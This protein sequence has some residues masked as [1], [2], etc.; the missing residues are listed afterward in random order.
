MTVGMEKREKGG[1][2]GRGTPHSPFLAG[3]NKQNMPSSYNLG[4]EDP[5]KMDWYLPRALRP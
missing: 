3:L 1:E 4:P 2:I 5:R